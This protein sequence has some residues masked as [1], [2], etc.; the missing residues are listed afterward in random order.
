[1]GWSDWGNVPSWFSFGS[2]AVAAAVVVRDR[3]RGS[4]E[5]ASR[6]EFRTRWAEVQPIPGVGD[7]LDRWVLGVVIRN[8]ST[9]PI[10]SPTVDVVSATG[11]QMI[12][13]QA[14]AS[15]EELGGAFRF[16]PAMLATGDESTAVGDR[17]PFETSNVTARLT[18]DDASGRTWVREVKGGRSR[19]RS[20]RHDKLRRRCRDLW[21]RV[22]RR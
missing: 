12:E 18:F 5:Q 6:V 20:L 13:G 17:F 16:Q 10:Y 9:S 22:I 21:T 2:F 1:M 11:V 15:G 3:R 7:P 8:A 14:A 4:R 19:L